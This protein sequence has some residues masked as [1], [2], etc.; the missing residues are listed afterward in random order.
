MQTMHTMVR[1]KKRKIPINPN[2]YRLPHISF[3]VQP[4][5][6][7]LYTSIHTYM[8]FFLLVLN[9]GLN[10]NFFLYEVFKNKMLFR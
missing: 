1:E 6:H 2:K 8:H 7:I 10:A 5:I 4:F 9:E 3:G